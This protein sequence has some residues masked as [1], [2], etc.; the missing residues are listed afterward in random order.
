MSKEMNKLLQK[1]VKNDLG[2]GL[3]ISLVIGLISSFMNAGIYLLGICVALINFIV[4]AKI[5]KNYLGKEKKQWI[6][7]ATSYLRMALIII[8]VLPIIKNTEYI[9]YYMIGFISHYLIIVVS[10][11][12]NRKGSV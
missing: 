2:S 10:N 8:T 3:L 4:N 11:I 5:I 9:I 7:V 6:I 1:T 12:K